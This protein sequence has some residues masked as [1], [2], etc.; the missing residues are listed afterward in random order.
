MLQ[1]GQCINRTNG[2]SESGDKAARRLVT[3]SMVE[4]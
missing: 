3:T 2:N 4:N 1:W